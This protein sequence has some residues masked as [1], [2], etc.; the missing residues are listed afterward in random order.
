MRGVAL[1][2]S[3]LTTFVWAANPAP[4][5]NPNWIIVNQTHVFHTPIAMTEI[6]GSLG[7]QGRGGLGFD[8]SPHAEIG[9]F[10]EYREWRMRMAASG[11]L[12]LK[13]SRICYSGAL[14]W[15]GYIF[16][17]KTTYRIRLGGGGG[18]RLCY[19]VG[20]TQNLEVLPLVEALANL[21]LRVIPN[22]IA[23]LSLTFGFPEGL[24]GA[25]GFAL[26]Y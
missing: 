24:G 15:L 6:V 22:V 17:A 21:Q 8:L 13:G 19:P 25:V 26:A 3:L 12:G 10:V 20:D 18:A 16:E 14:D 7:F 1:V 23:E 9:G 4:Q 11:A 2:F 5:G